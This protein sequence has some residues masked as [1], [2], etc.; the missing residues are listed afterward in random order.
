MLIILSWVMPLELTYV[1]NSDILLKAFVYILMT[2]WFSVS[3]NITKYF[4]FI[5]FLFLVLINK[6]L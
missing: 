4:C 6:G 3:A 5:T 1:F 2:M